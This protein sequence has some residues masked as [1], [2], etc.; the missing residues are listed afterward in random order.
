MKSKRN[1]QDSVF[2]D[3]I[4]AYTRAQAIED[5]VLVDVSWMAK[6]AGIRFPVALTQAVWYEYVVPSQ[7][8]EGFGQSENGRL[9]DVL[10]MFRNAAVKTKGQ[11]LTFEVLFLMRPGEEADLVKL[12]GHIGPGDNHEPVITIM[13]LDED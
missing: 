9:W 11:E 12:K 8:L 5:G 4:Y 13:K 7:D 2:G 6:E 3:I 1:D 10:W